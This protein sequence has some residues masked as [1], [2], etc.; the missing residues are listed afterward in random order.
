MTP[1]ERLLAFLTG[2]PCDMVPVWLLFP[3]HAVSYY[4]DVRALPQ[5][6]DIVAASMEQQVI[7]LNRR[8]F[9]APV[10]SAEVTSSY[11]EVIEGADIVKR[12]TLCYRT[13]TL[14]SEQRNGPT[15]VRFKPLLA[16]EE[17]LAIYAQFPIECDERVITAALDPQIAVW[18]REKAEFPC[19]LGAMMSDVGEPISHLYDI[20]NLEEY[21]IWSLTMAD[22]MKQL[23]DRLMVHYRIIYRYLLE[24]GV[25]DV[26]FTVGS[27][28]A[29]PPLVSRHTFQQWVVPYA[30]DLNALVHKYGKYV[31]QHYHGQIKEIL[32]DF[33]T[34]APDALHTIEAP[35]VGNCTL[36]EAFSIVGDH[37]GLIGNIQYDEFH[38]LTPD[39]M[40]QAVREVLGECCGKRFMLSPTTGPYE[41]E[42]TPRL[43]ENYLRFLD[44]AWHYSLSLPG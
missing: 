11:E 30:R 44:T 35:P 33:L 19:H 16:S 32:P 26:F 31:I 27:E 41:T 3:Y 20:S 43:R 18:R 37:I 22:T 40:E 23:L 39:E 1:R 8:N 7:W 12:T 2:A 9:G 38:R 6:R 28:L 4:A 17:D 21:A 29:S 42:V 36:S 34:M 10:H 5:Y 25:G 15:G 14:S 24:Q 13:L